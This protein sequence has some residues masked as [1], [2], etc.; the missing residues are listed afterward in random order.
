MQATSADELD[1]TCL[2]TRNVAGEMRRR[3]EYRLSAWRLT[4]ITHDACLVATEL[5]ANA[6]RATPEG[7]I[8]IR[9][10]RETGTVLFAVWDASDRMPE[11]RRVKILEPEDLSSVSDDVDAN[12]G[13]GLPI[14][15][16]TAT[17]TGVQRTTPTGKW[18]WARLTIRT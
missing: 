17:E 10:A 2:A 9:F 5:I 8:R 6:C 18:V 15:Q 4:E 3:I 12:G 13:W 11:P 14:V 16:A 1:V 7:E